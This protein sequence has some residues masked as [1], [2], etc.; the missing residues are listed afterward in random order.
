LLRL[1]LTPWATVLTP[2]ILLCVAIQFVSAWLVLPVPYT[3]SPAFVPAAVYF[4][5]T[6]RLEDPIYKLSWYA[7][8]Q[9]SDR[10]LYHGPLF[11]WLVGSLAPSATPRGAFLVIA[12]FRAI[13]LAGLGA[14]C[15]WLIGGGAGGA[16]KRRKLLLAAVAAAFLLAEAGMR[17]PITGRPESLGEVFVLLATGAFLFLPR[18][19][20][21]AVVAICAGLLGATHL[22]GAAL[23]GAC[24]CLAIVWICPTRE[25]IRTMKLLGSGSLALALAVLVGSPNGLVDTL[26]GQWIQA[27]LLSHR[28][29][30]GLLGSVTQLFLQWEDFCFL[31]AFLLLAVLT[32]VLRP[33]MVS[34]LRHRPLALLAVPAVLLAIWVAAFRFPA[35]SYNLAMFSS[36]VFLLLMRLLADASVAGGRR[37]VVGAV[38]ALVCA[39]VS[40]LALVKQGADVTAALRAGR[41]YDQARAAVAGAMPAA[42]CVLVDFR[43]WPLFDDYDRM[44]HVDFGSDADRTRRDV[45]ACRP[46]EPFLPLMLRFSGAGCGAWADPGAGRIL[47]DNRTTQRPTLLG[48]PSA[49]F[50]AGYAAC[51]AEQAR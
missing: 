34:G 26:H 8:P 38:A 37:F 15:I 44:R 47:L 3:D 35:T 43:S 4:A 45:V 11:P 10:F 50:P 46:G 36:S 6:G 1:R 42:G 7:D 30:P 31:G 24:A 21:L 27:Q 19:W 48:H 51:L 9:K 17:L 20:W 13:V 16:P 29:N 25:A 5:R 2:V 32:P 40:S 49:K 22:I 23:L 41:S 12:A 28:G 14:G 18:R 39:L 33:G